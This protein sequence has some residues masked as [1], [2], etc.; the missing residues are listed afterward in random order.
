MVNRFDSSKNFIYFNFFDYWIL[1]KSIFLW[2]FFSS[3]NRSKETS[4]YYNEDELSACES[5]DWDGFN[6]QSSGSGR[7]IDDDDNVQSSII[8]GDE[9]QTSPSSPAGPAPMITIRYNDPGSLESVCTYCRLCTL[10]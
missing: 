1:L 5:L 3:I 4:Q 9:L 2:F 10:T 7:V 8:G 6:P